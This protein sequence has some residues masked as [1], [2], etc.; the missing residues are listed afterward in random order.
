[1]IEW[2]SLYGPTM[3]KKWDC[4]VPSRPFSV[5]KSVMDDGCSFAILASGISSGVVVPDPRSDEKGEIQ[6]QD[7]EIVMVSGVPLCTD[8]GERV[9]DVKILVPRRTEYGKQI[10]KQYD[11]GNLKEK[12]HNMIELI[13]RD[14]DITNV[15]TTLERD[16]LLAVKQGENADTGE[17]LPDMGAGDV[18]SMLTPGRKEKRQ[19]GPRF[20]GDGTSFTITCQDKHG[21]AMMNENEKLRIRYLTER[22]CMRLMGQ[23]DEDIDRMFEVE[24]SKTVRYRLAGNSIVVDVLEA[25][26]KGIYI[27]NS[28]KE[29]QERQV[30]LDAFQ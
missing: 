14:D 1:M 28:F 7:N 27:D 15:I 16:N 6:M 26:F 4:V 30:S 12:R 9:Q 23:K 11:S 18:V 10:R 24:R 29:C 20:K 21:V 25:I 5:R 3:L 22:E 17:Q 2:P 8:I 19:N 13:P